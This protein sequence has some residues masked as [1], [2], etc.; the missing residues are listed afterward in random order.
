MPQQQEPIRVCEPI[1]NA[2][3]RL[4]GNVSR[5]TPGT[6]KVRASRDLSTAAGPRPLLPGGRAVDF[7]LGQPD[8]WPSTLRGLRVQLGQRDCRARATG[9]HAPTRRARVRLPALH[10]AS[11]RVRAGATLLKSE[12]ERTLGDFQEFFIS[13]GRKEPRVLRA[14]LP[15]TRR[16]G[17]RVLPHSRPGL[18][19]RTRA[20][21]SCRATWAG[22]PPQRATPGPDCLRIAPHLSPSGPCSQAAPRHPAWCSRSAAGY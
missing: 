14:R 9:A 7:E 12:E 8:R 2:K 18:N 1:H 17:F 15:L 16:S 11:S 4:I 6:M 13:D 3:K 21:K 10:S 19:V 22:W 20:D 5:L